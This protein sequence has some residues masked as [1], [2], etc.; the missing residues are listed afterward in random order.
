MRPRRRTEDEQ[1]LQRQ[2]AAFTHTDP[3]RVMRISAELVEGFERLAEVGLAVTIFGSAR[4]PAGH[5]TYEAAR[6][7]GRLFA[8]SGFAVVTGG[9]PGLMEAANLG[10]RDGG[11]LS[12]GCNIELPHEQQGNPYANLSM[13]FRYFFV[14]KLM[15]VK[16][17]EGFVIFPGGFGTLDELFEAVTLVQTRKI[18]QFPIVLYDSGYWAGMLDWIR[19]RLLEEG[20]ISPEDRELLMVADSPQ[21]IVDQVGA[22]VHGDCD[23]PFHRAENAL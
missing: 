4:V 9:G 11:G 5:P 3:W 7:T 17:S 21:A 2:D 8:E 13:Q 16:Y 14:R 22:C 20:K 19:D 15:F 12:I 18:K 1:L 23:H 6:E 10:A